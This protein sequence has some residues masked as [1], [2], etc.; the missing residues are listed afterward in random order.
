MYMSLVGSV[1]GY[2]WI[3]SFSLLHVLSFIYHEEFTV[4]VS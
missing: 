4:K 2:E 3:D 1:N